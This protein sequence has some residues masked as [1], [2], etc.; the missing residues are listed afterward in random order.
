MREAALRCA[1]RRGV[2]APAQGLE[3]EQSARRKDARTERSPAPPREEEA[4]IAASDEAPAAAHSGHGASHDDV[5][6]GEDVEI[7]AWHPCNRA[8]RPGS[9]YCSRACSNK[10]ARWRYKQRKS[11]EREAA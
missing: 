3:A 1:G 9:K 7:C 8:A 6:A 10:N 11:S 2:Q 5:D 4:A